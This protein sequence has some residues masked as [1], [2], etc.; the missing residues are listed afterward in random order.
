MPAIKKQCTIPCRNSCVYGC[1]ATVNVAE[2]LERDHPSI[3][4][5][6]F[7]DLLEVYLEDLAREGRCPEFIIGVPNNGRAVR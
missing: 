3:D 7:P 2:R 5:D 1:M 6:I 4:L